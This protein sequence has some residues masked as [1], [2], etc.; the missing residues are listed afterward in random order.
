MFRGKNIN[1]FPNKWVTGV[2]IFLNSRYWHVQWYKHKPFSQYMSQ[3]YHQVAFVHYSS[4]HDRSLHAP[5]SFVVG[6]QY[7]NWFLA[8]NDA[9]SYTFKRNLQMSTPLFNS[10]RFIFMITTK[11]KLSMSTANL[12]DRKNV[13]FSKL[14]SKLSIRF[15]KY[16]TQESIVKNNCDDVSSKRNKEYNR[17]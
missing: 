16:Q 5:L 7:V 2:I 11:C 15:K 10:Q 4:T 3:T 17:V 9:E 1:H 13:V 8:V 6:L 12:C 14:N